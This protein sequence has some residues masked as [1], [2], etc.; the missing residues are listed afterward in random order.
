MRNIC[1][2]VGISTLS[3]LS[4][5]V[6]TRRL[7]SGQLRPGSASAQVCSPLL[8]HRGT[9]K[10]HLMKIVQFLTS[11]NGPL[12]GVPN[13]LPLYNSQPL[14]AR[15]HPQ[16]AVPVCLSMH[17]TVVCVFAMAAHSKDGRL[18]L[19]FASSLLSSHLSF[20]PSSLLP[21][22]QDLLSSFPLR[23]FTSA[24]AELCTP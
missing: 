13:L 2:T 20:L 6:T 19:A 7:C 22:Q 18:P 14:P 4:T 24:H 3:N 5:H 11:Q 8:T 12:L 1:F 17:R 9:A 16:T 10:T 21:L 23:I 15:T